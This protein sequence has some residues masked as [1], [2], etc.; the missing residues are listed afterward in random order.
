MCLGAGPFARFD[1]ADRTWTLGNEQ[2]TAVFELDPQGRFRFASLAS[3]A[4]DQWRAADP[5][6]APFSVTAEDLVVDGSSSFRLVSESSEPVDRGGLRQTIVLD[7][8]ELPVRLRFEAEVYPELP[9]LR[10][11]TWLENRG[12]RSFT[13]TEANM[14]N[15][16]LAAGGRSF[17]AFQVNQWVKGGRAGN[18]EPIETAVMLDGP[19][20]EVYSGAHAQHCAW[21]AA[22]D[23][24]NR[25]LVL[26]W[27]FDGRAL[28]RLRQ[29]SPGG[30]LV[31]TGGPEGLFH[32]VAPG[33]Q[34]LIP[35]AFIGL[36]RGDWDTASYLTHRFTEAALA[37]PI[38][39]PEA[40]PYLIWDSW[41]YDQ[42]IDEKII[43]RAADNARRIGVEVMVLD[44]GW[45]R[46]IGDWREDPA[47]FPGG[48]RALSD[49]V[50]S[51]GMKFGLHFALTEASPEAPM[52][53]RNPEW[54]A[55]DQTWYYRAQP[56]CLSHRPAREWIIGEAVRMIRE[57]GVDWLLID[58][59]NMVKRCTRANH[60]HDPND[61]NY[62]NAVD[63]LNYVVDAI[64]R[65]APQVL[66][67]NCQDGGNMMTFSMVQRF[68]TS[69]AAD[70]YGP[71]W[72]RQA[73]HGV[74]YPFPPRYA[75]RYMPEGVL[76]DS[77][78]LSYMFGG[79]WIL[80]NRL[81]DW[82][83]QQLDKAAAQV[84]LYK[85]LRRTIRDGRVYHLSLRPAESR[86]D[87]IQSFD[88]A[89]GSAVIFVYREQSPAAS[90]LVR[91]RGLRPGDLY[92]V[93]FEQHP[94]SFLATGAE[95]VSD[96][97]PVPLPTPHSADIVYIDPAQ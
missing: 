15:W 30:A 39:D 2:I 70:E 63:G 59:E 88:A 67:E 8:L 11:R 85:R 41:A 91:P 61:S 35:G 26:G 54:F 71:L 90:R 80:M 5:P 16:R 33:Q 43:R 20:A 93:R 48:L 82:T 75:D 22:R 10:H 3:A 14:V 57:Y 62:S 89:S 23:G 36:F 38:P 81:A 28:I 83:G 74:T 17:R 76:D 84:A 37:R 53:R 40:F 92:R 77:A 34:F 78:T 65:Q 13:V 32:P 31:I 1:P 97:I 27:E 79:P 73:V 58:G 45:A 51:L 50:R 56:L 12:V 96:G 44:L 4:G 72:T 6:A 9:V 60:S 55:N 19:A 86:T 68:V 64:Q 21:L 46:A 7:H 94:R 52:L 49:Y 25:G 24:A 29:R 47:K 42:D 95:L 87:A 66:W 18:F 69:I